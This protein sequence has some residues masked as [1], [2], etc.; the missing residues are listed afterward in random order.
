MQRCVED[1]ET[2][3]A[4]A[5][6]VVVDTLFVV[7]LEDVA[8]VYEALLNG[9]FHEPAKQ[10]RD[11]RLLEY[12][13]AGAVLIQVDAEHRFKRNI[14]VVHIS[15]Q[16]LEKIFV[17]GD[18]VGFPEDDTVVFFG[19]NPVNFFVT[20]FLDRCTHQLSFFKNSAKLRFFRSMCIRPQ[21]GCLQEN[22][23]C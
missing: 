18:D 14:F 12:A 16:V 5:D 15:R 23:Q 21:N 8:V 9:D 19:K 22:Y 2:T 20:Q 13:I 11:E 7:L 1:E 17:I 10:E 3:V 4:G 6:K